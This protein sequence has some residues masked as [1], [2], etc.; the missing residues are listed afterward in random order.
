VEQLAHVVLVPV[1]PPAVGKSRLVGLTD[2]QRRDL[3]A[4]F[5]LDTVSACLVAPGVAR[6]LAVTDDAG[7]AS[8]LAALGCAVV[9]DGRPGDLNASLVLAAAEARRRWPQLRPAAVCADLPALRPED[10][11][12]VLTAAVARDHGPAFV[13]DA[14]GVGTTVYTAGH[15]AFLPQFGPGSRARHLASGV[16]EVADAPAS[17]RLDVDDLAALARARALGLGPHT[18]SLETD[19]GWATDR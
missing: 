1:K 19:E 14:D 3:A 18:R 2:E 10:L 5:A 8:R 4:A 17:V 7:F 13:A 11:A 9:P 15:A 6:V 16:T 12:A